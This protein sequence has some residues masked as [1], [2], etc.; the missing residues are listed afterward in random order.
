MSDSYI[1]SFLGEKEKILLE[2]RQHWFLLLAS[3]LMEIVIILVLAGG[4]IALM[5]FVNPLFAFAFL[6]V[7]IPLVSMIKD[8]LVFQNR[9]FIIT[10]RRVIEIAG[11]FNKNVTDSSLEKV[12]D[13]KMV[14][15]FIGRIFN[16]GDI[17]ILTASELGA[18]EFRYIHDPIKFKTAML[19]AKERLPMDE[20]MSFQTKL[21]KSIPELINDLDQ[22][23]QKGIVSDEEF[24]QKK[25]ELLSR[26]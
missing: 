19:N 26:M 7:F 14:Q 12:N 1:R 17:Q 5:T 4:V 9:K 2:T 25:K 6:L 8:I 11:V 22:L 20:A 23:R 18:N 24:Q 21:E 16:F 10:N 13:V 3:I 15:S